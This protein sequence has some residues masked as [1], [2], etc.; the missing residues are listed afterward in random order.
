M[1]KTM[2]AKPVVVLPPARVLI[3]KWKRVALAAERMEVLR[4]EQ[5]AQKLKK[6]MERNRERS[7]RL[8]M[9]KESFEKLRMQALLNTVMQRNRAAQIQR[10]R[11]HEDHTKR[12]R[13]RRCHH[14]SP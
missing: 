5:A 4:Q 6:K 11:V 7:Y 2:K 10:D 13:K 14:D 12:M 1:G 8:E 9:F 3:P